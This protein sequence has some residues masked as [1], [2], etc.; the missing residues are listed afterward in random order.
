MK[1]ANF[2][3]LFLVHKKSEP[4]DSQPHEYSQA[5]AQGHAARHDHDRGLH[6]LL[7]P[8][9]ARLHPENVRGGD[10]PDP[11]GL[12]HAVRQGQRVYQPRNLLLPERPSKIST[13]MLKFQN[14]LRLCN[15][16]C[17]TSLFK[18]AL[19]CDKM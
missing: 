3:F 16:Y 7:G 5:R 6:G 11:D 1:L 18:S 15:G 14:S 13:P 12:S 19:Q 4:P 8:L 9:R 17:I 2:L 10:D